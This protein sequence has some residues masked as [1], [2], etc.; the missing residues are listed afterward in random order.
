MFFTHIRDEIIR[1]DQRGKLELVPFV[2]SDDPYS[3]SKL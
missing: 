2:V 1:E 3:Y